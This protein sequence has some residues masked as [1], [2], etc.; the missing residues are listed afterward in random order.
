MAHT[1]TH[2]EPFATA[3]RWLAR[4]STLPFLAIFLLFGIGAGFFAP[5]ALTAAEAIQ[6]VFLFITLAGMVAGWRHELSGGFF[7]LAG[8]LAFQIVNW[9][10]TGHFAGGPVFPFMGLPGL[11][12]LLSAA[13]HRVIR[14]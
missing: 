13:T 12:F 11:L 14:P 10:K 2:P 5:A 1:L 6:F 8:V 9:S 7:A 4:A 3:V